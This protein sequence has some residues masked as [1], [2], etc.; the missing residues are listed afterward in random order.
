VNANAF[1]AFWLT[2]IPAWVYL[3]VALAGLSACVVNLALAW[4]DRRNARRRRS[5]I[6]ERTVCFTLIHDVLLT[7]LHVIN[8]TLFWSFHVDQALMI[9]LVTGG[10]LTGLALN[11]AAWRFMVTRS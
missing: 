3:T 11:G 4:A 8:L 5:V 6:L 10:G 1:Q 2:L 9:S 7:V